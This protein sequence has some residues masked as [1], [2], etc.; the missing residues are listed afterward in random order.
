MKKA[1]NVGSAL[2]LTMM[3]L[4]ASCCRQNSQDLVDPFDKRE[5]NLTINGVV[6]QHH[7]RVMNEI[8]WESGDQIG[9]FAFTGSD[10]SNGSLLENK[11][12]RKY[13]ATQ[14]NNKRA[15]TFTSATEGVWLTS[16]P[17]NLVAYYPYN[18]N[19]GTSFDNKFNVSDQSNHSKIDLLYTKYNHQGKGLTAT[20][21][22][23][24]LVFDHTL[25][26]IIFRI[27]TNYDLTNKVFDVYNP[28]VDGSLNL[29]NGRVA[30]GTTRSDVNRK[31]T[32]FEDGVYQAAFIL[33]AQN[34]GDGVSVHIPGVAKEAKPLS[35]STEQGYKYIINLSFGT[36]LNG[37]LIIEDAIINPWKDGKATEDII[38]EPEDNIVVTPGDPNEPGTTPTEG[39]VINAPFATDL[40]PFTAVNQMGAQE[41]TVNTKFSCASI[42]GYVAA[43]Q[44]SYANEDWL[45]SP[46]MDLTKAKSGK[47]NF[48]HTWNKG[49][50]TKMTEELTIWFTTNYTGDPATTQWISAKIPNYP[51]GIDWKY[52]ESGDVV[53]PAE[54]LGQSNVRFAL[55][56]TCTDASSGNWQIK[57][58]KATVTSDGSTQ[59]N[60]NP[61]PKPN[62]N[63]EPEPQPTT[64]NLLFPGADFEDFAAFEKSLNTY[65]LSFATQADG[66][67]NGSKALN[68]GNNNKN[69][70]LFTAV[71]PSGFSTAGKSKIVFYIKGTSDKSL[72][73]NVYIGTGNKMGTDYKCYNLDTV[74]TVSS[75]ITLEP[76]DANS[77]KNGNINTNGQWVKV[78]LNISGLNINSTA[79]DDLFAVKIAGDANNNLLMD[80]ITLE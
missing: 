20:D 10:L 7:T 13:E 32:K 70:Y 53:F 3:I 27:H 25:T 62:P 47:V 43:D 18:S 80:D 23:A 55:K 36:V 63:P 33:P 77:Y 21:N 22:A 35:I 72:S 75:D 2:L 46:A 79:G 30:T 5:G 37:N 59:P 78:T 24:N 76:T 34:L 51:T 68:I 14:I 54:V 42:S 1:I 49:D 60:P 48:E 44:R 45:V 73:F 65:G 38:L 67:R 58:L 6:T 31:I 41:W 17:A 61:D 29:V 39:E 74:A 50:V 9:V 52:V 69:S 28:I 40:A 15:G 57:N 66:G 12:N 8:E 19:L 16:E 64:G 4:M 56:Y 26:L 11:G 71:V